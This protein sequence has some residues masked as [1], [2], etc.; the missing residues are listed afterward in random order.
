MM[1]T[2]RTH[3]L[4]SPE[5]TC[6]F[7]R[8]LGARLGPGDVIALEGDIGAGKTHF[9]RCLIQSLLA[10]PED[11]PSP[12]YTLVQTYPGTG[13]EIWHA[14]LYRLTGPS[15]VFELGLIDAFETEVCL[16]EW[17]DRLGDL[18]P[19]TALWM[20]LT[21]GRDENTREASLHWSDPKWDTALK[22]LLT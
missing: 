20:R 4:A 11:V 16:V 22:G 21:Q 15:E 1:I 18:A 5:A 9:S 2:R 13:F 3:I 17:P 6:A 10:A 7:A 19:E 12:T 8:A 14:D